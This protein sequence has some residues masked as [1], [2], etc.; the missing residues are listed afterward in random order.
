ML[1]EEQFLVI[2][3]EVGFDMLWGVGESEGEFFQWYVGEV[4]KI[5]CKGFLVGVFWFEEVM[6]GIQ[7][8]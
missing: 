2:R 8:Q 4:Q 7:V 1:G 3:Y 5:C 6:D